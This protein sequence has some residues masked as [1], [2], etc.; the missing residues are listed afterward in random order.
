MQPSYTFFDHT[1]DMGLCIRAPTLPALLLPAAQ[2][3]YAAVGTLVP[4]DPAG[5][6]G[7][8][9]SGAGPALLL[10]DYLNELLVLWE[11]DRLRITSLSGPAFHD[12]RLIATARTAHIDPQR[13]TYDREVKAITYHE[14]G[15]RELADGF[16]A[17]FIVDI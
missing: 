5:A 4:G 11:R 16:E 2:G 9:F 8:T 7:F 3:L 12:Q 6:L 17:T 14:L 15:I 1:A 13:S 10:R